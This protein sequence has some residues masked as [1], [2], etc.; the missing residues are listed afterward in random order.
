MAGQ[1]STKKGKKA[2]KEVAHPLPE[3]RLT[4]RESLAAVMQMVPTD[5]NE[6]G[7]TRIAHAP[8]PGGDIIPPFLPFFVH[9]ILCG[10]VP[11]FSAFF[12][13]ILEHYQ[14]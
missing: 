4:S 11:P 14:I 1:G 9:T 5:Q 6:R 7:A 8:A 12:C 10:L 13:A 3:S 2:K